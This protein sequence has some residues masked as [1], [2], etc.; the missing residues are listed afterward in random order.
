MG[1]LS[2]VLAERELT[3]WMAYFRLSPFGEVRSDLQAGAVAAMVGNTMGGRKGKKSLKPSD[4]LFDAQIK[5]DP[6]ESDR[7]AGARARYEQ[8]RRQATK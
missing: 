4:F 5:D 1:E 7:L 3:E 8:K 6:D 2:S